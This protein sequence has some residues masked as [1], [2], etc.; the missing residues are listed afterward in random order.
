MGEKIIDNGVERELVKVAS[1]N[2]DHVGG[3]YVT[4]R[5]QMSPDDVEYQEAEGDQASTDDAG[6]Q[7][8]EDQKSAKKRK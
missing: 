4:Y 6:D 8:P 1:D 7:D 2:P 5:D 3:Y